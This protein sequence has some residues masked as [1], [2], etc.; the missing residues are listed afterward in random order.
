M[1]KKICIVTGTRAE[2]GLL[3]PLIKRIKEEKQ[4]QLQ[5]LVTGMHLSPEFGLTYKQ[6]EED[7]FKIDEKI[8]ILLSSDNDSGICKSVGLGMI[9]FSE[10]LERLNPDLIAVLGDRFE[11]FSLVSCAGILKIPVCHL[12]GGEATEGAYDEFFRHCITKTSYLHFTSTEEYRKRVIQLGES[13]ERVFNV[14]AIGLENIKNLKIIS[15]NELEEKLDIKFTSKIFVV[16][17]H[18]VTLEKNTA[19]FQLNELLKAIEIEN[20]DVIFI[21]GNAD[22]GGR[23]INRKI[24]EFSKKNNDKY[25]VFSS[26]TVEEYFSILK[27]SKGLIG[28]SSSGIVE[29]PYLK[30]GNLNIGDRQKGR[31]QSSSTL[32][33]NPIKEEIIEKIKIMLTD[34]YKEKVQKTISPYGDGEVS[35]KIIDIIKNIKNINLKKEFY[36]I[37]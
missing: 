13:P 19:E 29:L 10:V 22:S 32:N 6:I 17:F 28:N 18:P 1:I 4:L 36:D 2:Y 24:E 31:I 9:L 34:E 23:V 3:K 15:K 35:S 7:G 30:V 16:I 20:I 8:E 14:G 11:I 26:L 5:L 21:K 37:K 25:K 12:Y 27:Y 33:C